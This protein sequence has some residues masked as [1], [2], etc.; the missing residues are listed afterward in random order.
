MSFLFSFKK[1]LG[2]NERKN[3]A[4][5]KKEKIGNHNFIL[6]IVDSLFF[7]IELNFQ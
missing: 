3:Y 7:L 2:E 6:L 4:I 5:I 1:R